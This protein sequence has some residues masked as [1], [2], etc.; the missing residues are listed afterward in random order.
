MA[1]SPSPESEGTAEDARLDSLNAVLKEE[2]ENVSDLVARA[3][4]YLETKNF[5]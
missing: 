2:P 4:F 3:D 1:C 5:P